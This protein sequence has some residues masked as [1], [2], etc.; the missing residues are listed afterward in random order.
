MESLRLTPRPHTLLRA[1]NVTKVFGETVALWDV[2]LDARSGDLI[3]VHGANGS[4]KSTLLRILAGL[5]A[6]TRGRVTQATDDPTTRPRVA[7]LGHATHLFDE[8]TAIENVVLT[9]R[10]ARRDPEVAAMLLDRLGVID[11]GGRL[12]ATLSAGTRRRVG[13]ARVLA[14][15]PNIVLV[16]EPL[17]GLDANAADIV[18]RALAQ[19]RDEGR[20]VIVATHDQARTEVLASRVL[21]LEQGRVR[22]DESVATTEERHVV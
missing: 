22:E 2:T 18:G 6:P 5:M 17:A 1:S 13:L 20:L 4:G 19:A 21:R 7:Y 12:V 3:A 16:D 14:T 10:L 9:A 11:H 8:L 15:D